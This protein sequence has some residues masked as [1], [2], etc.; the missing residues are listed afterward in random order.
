[1]CSHSM[2]ASGKGRKTES[3]NNRI[4]VQVGAYN[5]RNCFGKDRISERE[6]MKQVS[7]VEVFDVL[8]ALVANDGREDALFGTCALHAREAFSRS[9][10]GDEFPTIWFEVPL[11]GEPRFDLHVAHSRQ[12]LHEGAR[13]ASG[14]G[15]GYEELFD[16][17]GANERG[18]NGLA[19][20][21]DISEGAIGTPAVHVNVNNAA[22]DD[23]DRFFQLAAGEG[24]ADVYRSFVKRLPLDWRVWYAGVHPG[25]PGAPIR[26]D[27]FV[28]RTRQDAYVDDADML[29]QDL[30]TCGFAASCAALQDLA[31]PILR[32]PFGLELQFDV[33]RDGTLG[34]TLGLS[35]SFGMRSAR[36]MRPLFERDG[37]GAVLLD[38]VE[39]LGLADE[40]W[41]CISNAMF[42]KRIGAG[43]AAL[44]LYCLPTF[45]KLRIREGIALDAK[46]YFQAG[47]R[48]L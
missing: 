11:A 37:A 13:F 22:L 28:N 17:Y 23:T 5:R 32:S 42:T 14:A 20:A 45:V 26:V 10:I 24:A 3:E 38:E 19:F 15:N 21:Y 12:A 40:R 33:L 36:Y 34:P 27:C 43:D 16:W 47:A 46:L 39:R 31:K 25:R 44:A 41:Q 18:G 7:Q 9:L 29:G 2:P 6:Q 4:A 35:A 1:M 30:R 8:Y 48:A